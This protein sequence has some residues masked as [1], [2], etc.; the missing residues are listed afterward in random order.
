MTGEGFDSGNPFLDSAALVK[1]QARKEQLEKEV[2]HPHDCSQILTLKVRKFRTGHDHHVY[3]CDVCGQQRGGPLGKAKALEILDGSSAD[4]YD[5]ALWGS[6]HEARTSIYRQITEINKAIVDAAD[7]VSAEFD[8]MHTQLH[9][10]ERKRVDEL[11]DQAVS[12]V[13][14]LYS[15][16]HRLA[17]IVRRIKTHADIFKDPDVKPLNRF[18]SEQ[19]LRAWL[20]AWIGEDFDFFEEVHGIHLTEQVRV[21]IDY[22]LKPRQHLVDAGFKP[23]PIGL[24]VKYL[25]QEDKFASRASRFVWQAVSYTDCEFEMPDGRIRLPQVLLFSNMSF[26]GERM[27]LKGVEP[28]ASENERAK[29]TALLELANHANVGCLV[30]DGPREKRSGWKIKFAA[31]TYFRRFRDEYSLHNA[32]LFSKVRIGNF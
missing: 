3:Q 10:E 25:L 15:W 17:M 30:I 13:A 24:E 19:E 21:Q 23:G 6:Y 20:N 16:N 22:I 18:R 2:E 28:N 27:L 7:P 32:H 14:K 31:G 11:I 26:E 29:W 8:A 4:A 1:L 12:G 9:E 5:E